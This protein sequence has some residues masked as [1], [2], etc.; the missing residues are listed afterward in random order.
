MENGRSFMLRWHLIYTKPHKEALV[1]QQL[2]ERGLDVFFPVL[3]VDRGYNRGVRAEPFFPH[4]LFVRVDLQSEQATGLRWLVG[5]RSLVYFDGQPAV[6]PDV[7]VAALQERLSPYTDKV[8]PRHE[9]R[10]TPGQKVLIRRG[11]FQGFEAIFQ[12][13]LRGSQRVQVLL[14]LLGQ[15]TR[16]QVHVDALEP[17]SGKVSPALAAV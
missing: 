13:G 8:V 2:E 10:F 11:P 3:H 1:S 15:W 4:Y 16:A 17:V 5:V 12:K 7:I 6:V 9:I 14:N